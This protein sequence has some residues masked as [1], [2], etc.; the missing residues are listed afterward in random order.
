MTILTETS[1]KT[2]MTVRAR[3]W[4]RLFRLKGNAQGVVGGLLVGF[5]VAFT[6]LAPWIAPFSPSDQDLY[7]LYA[8][9]SLSSGHLLGTDAIGQDMLSR[10]LYGGRLPLLIVA[11]AVLL[12][13]FVGVTMG[14]LAGA[15]GG[16]VDEIFGR[17]A[18][19]Q[20][21]LPSILL[22]L[23]LLAFAGV[24]VL[25][26]IIVIALATWPIQFRL[27]RAHTMSLQKQNFI[28]AAAMLG[29]TTWSIILRH[30]LPNVMPLVIV[31]STL[32]FSTGLL[33][34]ASLS[35]LGLGIQPPTPDWGQMVA[36]G[37][38]QLGAAWWMAIA[39][40]APLLM[41]LLGFQ[42]LGDWLAE[43]LSVQGL[44]KQSSGK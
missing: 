11:S 13:A 25:N 24:S 33:L 16:W 3:R 20:L 40:G 14:L 37:Q 23:V 7:S 42:M 34:E 26:L 36:A 2:D 30:S 1:S 32:N 17:M 21:A 6:L 28:E 27:T 9:P 39:P 29:G 10:V 35:Y 12:S 43:R 38:T 4:P 41:L 22:A 15:K 31:T 19:I 5:V 8:P 44:V 18:D